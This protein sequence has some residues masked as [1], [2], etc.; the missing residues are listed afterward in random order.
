MNN[1]ILGEKLK[2]F[3]N[4]KNDFSELILVTFNSMIKLSIVNAIDFLIIELLT[5]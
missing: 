4:V 2:G 3:G 1:I 5:F